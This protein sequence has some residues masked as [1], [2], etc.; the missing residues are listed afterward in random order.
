MT[1]MGHFRTSHG[2]VALV[3]LALLFTLACSRPVNVAT[4]NPGATPEAPF[5]GTPPAESAP[6]PNSYAGSLS[7]ASPQSRSLPFHDEDNVPAGT[8]LTVR[9][10]GALTADASVTNG[11]FEAVVD[12]PVVIDGGTVV[13][14]G[15]TVV[16][17]VEAV[18]ISKLKPQRGYVRLAL[19]SVRMGDVDVPVQTA[20]LFAR[21][22]SSAASDSSHSTVHLESGRR[23][24]FR[25]T[26]AVAL[27]AQRTQASR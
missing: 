4:E 22:T 24:T 11:S 18:R 23:L 13:P 8:L 20:S 26:E 6:G 16:G 7:S 25:L 10:R 14:R 12:Q 15:A 19:Q 17:R 3:V 2:P 27:N 1:V 5:Q 9:L 21:Q